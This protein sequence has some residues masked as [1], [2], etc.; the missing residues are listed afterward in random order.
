MKYIKKYC[1]CWGIFR[2]KEHSPEK[3]T[4]DEAILLSVA[5]KLMYYQHINIKIF[6]PKELP[7]MPTILP[8]LIFFMCEQD[9]ILQRLEELGKKG[10]I[11]VN[12]PKG[13][14]NTFRQKTVT[15]L[16]QVHFFPQSR[17]LC[18]HQ[19]PDEDI[20]SV[21]VK[22]GNYHAVTEEDVQ[23]ARDKDS[24][25]FILKEFDRRNI[26]SVVLQEHIP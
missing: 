6:S 7:E 26:S 13:V 19:I 3:E 21:W 24:L 9:E 22:R 2:E 20:R 15:L 8:D 12:E 4:D 5:D 10:I 1:E 25:I 17:L 14:R 18:P 23:Y 16:S 11:M